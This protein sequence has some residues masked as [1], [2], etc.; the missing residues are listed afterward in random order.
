[1]NLVNRCVW[2][3]GKPGRDQ[4]NHRDHCCPKQGITAAHGSLTWPAL[5]HITKIRV[6]KGRL[7]RHRDRFT[8]PRRGVRE[9]RNLPLINC[10]VKVI[11]DGFLK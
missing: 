4:H 6:E 9:V 8:E 10:Y 2:S 5:E 7:F 1:M 3:T 11:S